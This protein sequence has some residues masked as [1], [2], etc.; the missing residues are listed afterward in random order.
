MNTR[1]VSK[2]AIG[3]CK[4]I[5]GLSLIEIWKEAEDRVACSKRVSRVASTD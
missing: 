5:D 3:R 1:K 2:T 4:G